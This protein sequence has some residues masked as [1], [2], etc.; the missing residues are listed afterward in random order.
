MGSSEL[1][2]LSIALFHLTDEN[3]V[4]CYELVQVLTGVIL[5]LP[6]EVQCESLVAGDLASLDKDER[7][8]QVSGIEIVEH[9]GLNEVSQLVASLEEEVAIVGVVFTLLIQV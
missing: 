2:L 3:L 6:D 1:L 5:N 8:D 4:G 9:V 7:V